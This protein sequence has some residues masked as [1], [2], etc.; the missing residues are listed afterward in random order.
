MLLF[1][2]IHMPYSLLSKNEAHAL[3]WY[4]CIISQSIDDIWNPLAM[5]S[6]FTVRL[7]LLLFFCLDVVVFGSF[8]FLLPECS[9]FYGIAP[10]KCDYMKSAFM[11]ISR[12]EIF[13]TYK[14]THIW[15]LYLYIR[16]FKWKVYE[17][18]TFL[19]LLLFLFF[20]SYSA[21]NF[22][23]YSAPFQRI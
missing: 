6:F 1:I 13:G 18:E 12:M 11:I 5:K 23:C 16:Q 21:N 17:H 4:V 2:H 8:F 10:W 19:H 20:F 7:L 22:S 3:Q 9:S 14:H 15:V